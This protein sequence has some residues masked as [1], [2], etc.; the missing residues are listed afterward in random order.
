MMRNWKVVWENYSSIHRDLAEID[1][2]LGGAIMKYIAD[3]TSK[4][5]I[6]I[7]LDEMPIS[8]AKRLYQ[9]CEDVEDVVEQV[10][11]QFREMKKALGIP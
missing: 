7:S 2:V 5:E 3:P 8:V 11:S 1:K 4:I 9:V 10:D 6:N